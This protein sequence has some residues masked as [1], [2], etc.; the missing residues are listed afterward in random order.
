MISQRAVPFISIWYGS[1]MKKRVFIIHGWGG[2]PNEHWLPWLKDELEERGFDVY[3]PLMTEEDHAVIEEWDERLEDAIGAS[4]ENT[5]FV[6][7][8]VGCQTIMR[9]LGTR[10]EKAGG[11]VFV[12]GWFRLE[13]ELYEE[14]DEAIAAHEPWH[15]VPIDF[16]RIRRATENITVLISDD[17]P[18]GAI[19]ENAAMFQEKLNA[20]V[21]IMPGMGHFT[22]EDGIVELPEA[23][24]AVLA[25]AKESDD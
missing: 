24:E 8:S 22:S 12:A 11:C 18:Y 13:G 7:H 15:E 17:E 21:T 6:G 25:Y 2:R 14:G 23:L 19:E 1:A 3:V 16:G 5:Y 4:D 9:Y 10:D 20:D